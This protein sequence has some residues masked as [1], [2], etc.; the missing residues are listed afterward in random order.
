MDDAALVRVVDGG[1]DRAED[2]QTEAEL[3][4]RDHLRPA[5]QP[6]VEGPARGELHGEVVA[7]VIGVAGL[8]DGGDV[9]V[10]EPRQRLGLAVEEAGVELVHLVLAAHHLERHPAMRPV[11]LRL[12]HRTHPALAE[13]T[14]NAIARDHGRLGRGPGAPPRCAGGGDGLL[15][16]RRGPQILTVGGALPALVRV[17]HRSSGSLLL[18]PGEREG[19]FLRRLGPTSRRLVRASCHESSRC[20]T[21]CVCSARR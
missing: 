2:P 12:P 14:E 19:T 21:R 8:V 1:A 9:G 6:A 13:K 15:R 7:A 17:V 10:L 4:G 5:A 20:T 3:V 16:L 18:Q 11:L